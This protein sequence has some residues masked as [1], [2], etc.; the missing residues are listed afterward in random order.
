ML[1]RISAPHF[2][3]GAFIRE[4]K[5]YSCAPII[6]YMMGWNK[7]TVQKYCDKKGWVFET[8]PS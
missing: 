8:I 7:E 6:K 5:V 1:I 2:V 3:A 4:N